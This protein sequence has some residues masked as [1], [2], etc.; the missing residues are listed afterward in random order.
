MAVLAHLLGLLAWGSCW[1]LAQP[2]C[3]T[4]TSYNP[5]AAEYPNSVSGVM[6]GT[7]S[8][9]LM[10]RDTASSWLPQGYKFLDNA[11]EAGFDMW[12]EDSWP[13]LV[14]AVYI[15]DTRGPDDQW[16]NDHTVCSRVP[17]SSKIRNIWLHS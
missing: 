14:K 3:Q 7:F 2:G 10:S 15:H 11:Y 6:N 12:Q 16:R 5:I 13:V 4:Q 17:I 9:S 8:L 1:A